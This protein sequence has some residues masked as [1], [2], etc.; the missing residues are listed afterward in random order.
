MSTCESCG[1]WFRFRGNLFN[2]GECWNPN[3][4]AKR[5]VLIVVEGTYHS[6]TCEEHCEVGDLPQVVRDL[7]G[8][9][10]GKITEVIEARKKST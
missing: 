10:E 3:G 8:N 6:D 2:F 7:L 1:C 4:T 9:D 5:H